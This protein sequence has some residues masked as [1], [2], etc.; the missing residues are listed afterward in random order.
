MKKWRCTVCGYIH[1]GENP[2]DVCPVCGVGPEMFEEVIDEQPA[3]QETAKVVAEAYKQD[4]GTALF[5]ISYGLYIVT[6]VSG[7]KLNGQC[8][9]SLFQITSQPPQVAVG[10]NKGNLTHEY[11]MESGVFAATILG[12][13]GHDLVRRFGYR[14]G[15]ETNKLEGIDFFK[16]EATGAPVFPKG[17]AYLECKVLK[18]KCV[19]VGTHTLIVAEVVGGGVKATGEPMTYAYFRQTK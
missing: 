1:E 5:K 12:Q 13:N 15:R 14:S 4:A 2:P 11:I 9:N 17:I 8:C 18:D 19:D 3:A 7:E 16:G 10:I 6:S